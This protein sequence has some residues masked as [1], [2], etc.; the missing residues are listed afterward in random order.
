[1][2]ELAPIVL[3]EKQA[4]KHVN[5]AART[6]QAMRLKG[7]GPPY[8][9]LTSRRVGYLVSDL[10]AW[11]RQRSRASTSAATVAQGGA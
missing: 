11:A 6:M 7:D 1:V 9:A 4:G 8:V 10:E 2:P 5:L 3:S